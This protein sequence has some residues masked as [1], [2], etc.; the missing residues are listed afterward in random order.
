MAI[1]SLQDAERALLAARATG[2]VQRLALS[3]SSA[4]STVLSR[5][6]YRLMASVDCFIK[7]GGSSVAATTTASI[8]LPQRTER[9]V[10]VNDTTDGYVAGI[11][12]S[13]SGYLYIEAV[14]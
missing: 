9:W 8:W 12:A 3:T 4:A 13:G 6:V 7:Q 14:G 1:F 10:V 2:T 11:T 5:G